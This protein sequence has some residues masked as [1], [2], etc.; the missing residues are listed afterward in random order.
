MLENKT[1]VNYKLKRL[2]V[3]IDLNRKQL[4]LSHFAIKKVE[5]RLAHRPL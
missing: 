3:Y 1:T 2:H 5:L 4:V